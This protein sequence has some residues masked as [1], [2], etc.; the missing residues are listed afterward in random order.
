MSLNRRLTLALIGILMAVGALLVISSRY[1]AQTYFQEVNQH[2]NRSIAMYVVD[3]LALFADSGEVDTEVFLALAD[4]AMTVNPSVEVYLLD[5]QGV[6][7]ANA[8]AAETVLLSQVSLAPIQAFLQAE[9]LPI[10]GD[11]PRDPESPQVFSVH[12]IDDAQRNRRLG[13]LYVVLGGQQYQSLL[14]MFSGSYVMRLASVVMLGALLI[15]ALLGTWL[16]GRATRPL[17]ALQSTVRAFGD[18]GFRDAEAL[19]LAPSRVKE[20]DELA[21]NFETMRGQLLAQFEQ[22]DQ[23]DRLRRELLANVSH[24]LRTPLAAMQGYVE[25]LLLKDERLTPEQRRQYLGIAHNHTQQ[26]SR[27]IAELFELAK[28]DSGTLQPTLEPFSLTELVADVVQEF[29]LAAEKG[30]IA[31]RI[32]RVDSDV[33]VLGDIGLIQR[34]CENLVTNALRHTPEG[35]EVRFNIQPDGERV[36]VSLSDTGCGIPAEELPWI[37]DRYY[38]VGVKPRLPDAAGDSEMARGSGLGLAIVK[39]ILQLHDSDISVESQLEAG[40]TFRFDLHTE[41]SPAA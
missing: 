21:E 10:V 20:I 24:D 39:K 38:R 16:F 35:G 6:I 34:V 26:L 28:L 40:T 8:L 19:A 3:R 5:P 22:L 37:F 25:T 23:N 7:L 32:G 36:H 1:A 17:L 27:L 41:L 29:Q 11:D 14:E 31:L 30:G 9:R 2:L 18:K 33:W 15:G 13:Y 4:Q 12:P